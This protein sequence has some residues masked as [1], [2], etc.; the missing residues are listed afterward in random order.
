MNEFKGHYADHYDLFH[1][2]KNYYEEMQKLL[3][4]LNDHYLIKDLSSLRFLDFGCGTGKHMSVLRELGINVIGYDLSEDMLKIAR[5]NNSKDLVFTSNLSYKSDFDIVYSLFDVAS[6]Q[7]TD[8]KFIAYLKQIDMVL[9][10]DGVLIFD[11]WHSIGLAQSPPENRN[12]IVRF[13]DLEIARQVTAKYLPDSDLTE[14]SIQLINTKTGKIISNEI[15]KL[16]SF[17]LDFITTCL[18]KLNYRNIEFFDGSDTKAKVSS[19]SWRFIVFAS[20]IF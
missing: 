2:N 20:K 9:A 4:I 8:E 7:H 11:G 17:S 19:A 1:E 13:G 18:K 6:Y 15:H 12:R 16:R 5:Q 3:V 14:L 10:R